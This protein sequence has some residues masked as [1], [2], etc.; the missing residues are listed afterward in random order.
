MCEG[1][2]VESS[3]C[4]AKPCRKYPVARTSLCNVALISGSLYKHLMYSSISAINGGFADWSNWSVCS[5]SCGRGSKSRVRKCI[6]PLPRYGGESCER[7]GPAEEKTH[8]NANQ[9]PGMTVTF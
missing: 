4:E 2:L 1:D 5:R 6:N 8:C 9:C 7:L 3:P